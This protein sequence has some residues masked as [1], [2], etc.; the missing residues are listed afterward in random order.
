[1][2]AACHSVNRGSLVSRSMMPSATCSAVNFKPVLLWFGDPYHSLIQ[3]ES[4]TRNR[5]SLAG[6]TCSKTFVLHDRDTTPQK[7]ATHYPSP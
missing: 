3:N 5:Y 2:I 4:A 1:M 6:C 7:M